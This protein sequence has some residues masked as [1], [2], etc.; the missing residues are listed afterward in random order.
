[1][2]PKLLLFLALAAGLGA[3]PIRVA[4]FG[5][6]PDDGADDTRAIQQAI[7]HAI[8]TGATEVRFAPGRY[9]VSKTGRTR[10]DFKPEEF[11]LAIVG[12]RDLT[13]AGN[14]AELLLSAPVVE[15]YAD[16]VFVDRCENLRLTGLTID[17]L[18]PPYV[19]A[20]VREVRGQDMVLAVARGRIPDGEFAFNRMETFD[21][22]TGLISLEGPHFWRLHHRYGEK[23]KRRAEKLGGDLIRV[24]A[25][26]KDLAK[27]RMI[28]PG[29]TFVLSREVFG[30]E[31]MSINR[32]GEVSLADVTIHCAAGIAGRFYLCHDVSLEN[33]RVLPSND[34]LLAATAD[35]A[36]F[37]GCSGR[38]RISGSLFSSQGDDCMNVH[39]KYYFPRE[40]PGTRSIV[41]GVGW[42][43]TMPEAGERFG[44]VG[45]T[46]KELWD[47]LVERVE[48]RPGAGVLVRFSEPYPE[49]ISKGTGFYSLDKIPS[50][51]VRDS[52]F[53]G[54][55]GRGILIQTRDV[56][57]E[58][59]DFRDIYGPAIV[60]YRDLSQFHKE[61]VSGRDIRIVGNRFVR[62]P[63][64]RNIATIAVWSDI[65][66][67]SGG[68]EG[69]SPPGVFSDIA[70]EGN[71]FEE[72]TNMAIYASSVDGLSIRNNV[73]T[74][75]STDPHPDPDEWGGRGHSALAVYNCTG[76]RIAGN[77]Y[78]G[79]GSPAALV[80]QPL[81][82]YSENRVADNEGFR[83]FEDLEV[84]RETYLPAHTDRKQ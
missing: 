43:G 16:T 69:R 5:A 33:Y 79:P 53:E 65:H 9:L 74:G 84:F 2:T 71:A 54:N 77:R 6:A 10:V 52:T 41:L 80:F 34:R 27:W 24:H 17:W 11:A 72:P 82:P 57:V 78:E 44:A 3:E 59:C 64:S 62:A 38:I 83:I 32:S 76:V 51:D 26:A 60:V 23:S 70:I 22:E 25:D 14:G 37:N 75:T 68:R 29:M 47:G 8:E 39:G 7:D 42:P 48:R 58:N 67:G 36:H 55:R 45:P 49:S 73:L 19:E 30:F 21:R 61:A 1:M 66:D 81:P 35:A 28:R 63:R 56:R 50:L 46:G 20:E 40:F 4:D 31:G 12:A 15:D 13:L 18:H